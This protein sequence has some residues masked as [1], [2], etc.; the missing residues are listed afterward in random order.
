MVENAT[1]ATITAT[2]RATLGDVL[3]E[4]RR[5]RADEVVVVLDA[6]SPLFAAAADFH[7]LDAACAAGRIPHITF[8]VSDPHRIGLAVAFGY[9]TRSPA[10]HP[11]QSGIVPRSERAE[12]LPAPV[13]PIRGIAEAS[14]PSQSQRYVAPTKRTRVR[15]RV[16]PV[17][18]L[19]SCVTLLA[20][21]GGGM[22]AVWEMHAATVT[23]VPV[24][25]DFSET[26]PFAI[27]VA[28]SSGGNAR[29][30]VAEP[31]V[32]TLER[33]AIVTATG[34]QR[35]PDGTP[36]G[37]VTFRSKSEAAQTLKAGTM[38]KGMGENVYLLT[39]DVVIPGLDLVGGQLG[40]AT[41]K[42]RASVAGTSG[43]MQGG[44]SVRYTESLAA[45]FG[46]I[47]GGSEREVT[48]LTENDLAPVRADLERDIRVRAIIEMNRR[49]PTGTTALADFL[50]LAPAVITVEPAIGTPAATAKIHLAVVAQLP[51]YRENTFRDL[52]RDGANAALSVQAAQAG[53]L[54]AAIVPESVVTSPVR[55]IELKEGVFR[56][57][58]TVTGKTRAII[59]ESDVLRIRGMLVGRDDVTTR[60]ILAAEPA[61]H[62]STVAYGPSWLPTS[63]RDRMPSRVERITLTSGATA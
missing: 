9:R 51:A 30:L 52:V 34:K 28:P 48:I 16:W 33:D 1:Q 12:F 40:E 42:V 25:R 62:R 3:D 31:F 53:G 49:L 7:D 5:V 39:Q 17:I 36:S 26:V 18:A 56:Y 44:Y 24:E 2:P 54:H 55:F 4:L 6:R 50:T 23:L 41:A 21:A 14:L 59:D 19:L 47:T 46:P 60:Q 61:V 20:G 57:E 38:V 11:A 35:I 58:S 29:T 63:V 8:A 32:A 37:T 10:L 27:V 15:R 43:N 45:V 13:V 22:F